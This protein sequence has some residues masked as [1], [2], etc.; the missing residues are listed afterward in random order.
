[1]ATDTE[2]VD[3]VIDWFAKKGFGLAVEWRDLSA[4]MPRKLRKWGEGYW[5]DLI[6]LRTEDVFVPNYGSGPTQTLAVISTEQRWLVEQEGAGSAPGKS[7]VDKAEERLRRGRLG[8]P[9]AL[10]DSEQA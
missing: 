3:E 7:Y 4:I 9:P 2:Q 10:N 1:M 5:V 8:P 6:D